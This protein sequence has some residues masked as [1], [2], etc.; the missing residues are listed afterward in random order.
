[1]SQTSTL[2]PSAKPDEVVFTLNGWARVVGMV[3]IPGIISLYLVWWLTQ[4][5][6]GKLD[7]AL[8]PFG[9]F[10]APAAAL[11]YYLGD[12]LVRGYIRLIG[13]AS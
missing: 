3:G 11:T 2:K 5:V 6:G 7:R 10:L 8:V 4:W 12:G 13:A 1:M 9:F